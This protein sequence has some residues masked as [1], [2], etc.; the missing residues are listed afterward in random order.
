VRYDDWAPLY[1][2]IRASLGFEWEREVRARDLL[3]SL[4]PE[5][6]AETTLGEAARRLGGR[7]VV[8]VGLA[9]GAGP[10]PVWR[11]PAGVPPALIAA[12]GAAAVCLDA[13]L[14][15]DVVVTDLD[16]PVAS[17]VTAESRGALLIVH[18]HGDNL[19]ALRRW[20]PELSSRAGAS[21]A[22]PP[23]A[24]CLN[25]GGFTD[26]DR[27]AYLAG[28]AKAARI[29]LWG[30]DFGRAD[31]ADPAGRVRKIGKLRWARAALDRLATVG[32]TPLHVWRRDGSIVP[33][34][35]AAE[36]ESTQ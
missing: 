3:E 20:V 23:T 28:H 1:E 15:P 27:G 26:G 33:Y 34:A 16:G 4:V 29:L 2:R 12:D 25:V 17:E 5:R 35:P 11:L 32:A 21:W 18:A 24:I 9:P 30:F 22:G 6:R 8:I 19:E 31:D 10:P 7:T 14:V 36:P 13:G